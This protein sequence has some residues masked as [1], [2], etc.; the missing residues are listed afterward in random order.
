MLMI[1][2]F[3]NNSESEQTNRPHKRGEKVIIITSATF[4]KK[5]IGSGMHRVTQNSVGGGVV[6]FRKCTKPKE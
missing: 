2:S 5:K 4:L 1:H 3:R 6:F